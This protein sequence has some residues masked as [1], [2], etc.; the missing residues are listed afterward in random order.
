VRA[1]EAIITVV[2]APE[3]PLHLLL[4]RPAFEAVVPRSR[5]FSGELEAWREVSLGADFPEAG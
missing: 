1:A 3:P 4:G 2:A 5:I